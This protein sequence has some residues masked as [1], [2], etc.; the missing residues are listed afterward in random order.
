MKGIPEYENR[1]AAT[2]DG[3]IFSLKYRN[4][5]FI[6][7]LKQYKDTSG[8]LMVE[9]IT[10]S[11]KVH[12]LIAST[13]IPNPNNLQQVNHINGIKTD[14]RVENLEWCTH[15]ENIRHSVKIGLRENCRK[16]LKNVMKVKINDKHPRAKLS[17][18]NVIEIR[19]L[20]D[21]GTSNKE[22]AI[23]FNMDQS[24]ISNIKTRKIW[25][26]L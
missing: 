11:Y 6:K 19:R 12:R 18:S 26:N 1:Y 23:K 2:K 24:T 13:F 22:V 16:H 9:L 20:L 17:N 25:K 21:E 5:N 8:Y 15:G 4:Q 14:N 3:D 10:K 7:K